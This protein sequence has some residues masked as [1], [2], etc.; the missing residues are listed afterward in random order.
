[1][2]DTFCVGLVITEIRKQE[3]KIYDG[4]LRA[5]KNGGNQMLGNTAHFNT[6]PYILFGKLGGAT[7]DLP[8]DIDD[9][10]RVEIFRTD[11]SG[12]S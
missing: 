12:V 2:I 5:I 3:L 6:W 8:N 11:L 4:N 10:S 1:M 7:K 9:I